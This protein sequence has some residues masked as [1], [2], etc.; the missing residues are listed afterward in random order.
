[1]DF[2]VG[3]LL[4]HAGII[5][6]LGTAGVISLI[7]QPQGKHNAATDT[8]EK[9][10]VEE[11]E[12]V[13]QDFYHRYNTTRA[14]DLVFVLD[15]SYSVP[16][17][18]WATMLNFVRSLLEHFTVDKDNTRVAL[19]TFSTTAAVD[20]NDLR[21]D[22][23]RENKCTLTRRLQRTMW[24]KTPAGYTATHAALS[25]AEK[26]LLDSRPNAKKGVFVLTDGRSNI[27]PPPVRAAFDIQALTWN[28]SWLAE[29]YGP[30]VEMYALGI[31][32]AYMPELKSI[33]SNIPNHTFLIPDFNT[34]DQLARTL[35]GSKYI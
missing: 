27:G 33:S 7:P 29:R 8:D 25:L 18:G 24:R 12:R 31:Q 11:G 21:P 22:N 4:L 6:F 13:I 35:H 34:F 28:A 23:S 10:A 14:V 16:S 30:Q 1:M 2:S 20:V 15:R 26:V 9:R 3:S 5:S 32:D 19:I 17:T